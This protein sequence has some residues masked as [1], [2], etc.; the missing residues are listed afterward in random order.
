MNYTPYK[1]KRDANT[2]AIS[3]FHNSR[4]ILRHNFILRYIHTRNKINQKRNKLFQLFLISRISPLLFRLKF[5]KNRF[6]SRVLTYSQ[7]YLETIGEKKKKKK[8][9]RT[10]VTR[11]ITTKSVTRY[12]QK[13]CRNVLFTVSSLSRYYYVN[14][15]NKRACRGVGVGFNKRGFRFNSC[16]QESEPINRVLSQGVGKLSFEIPLAILMRFSAV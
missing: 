12:T 2:C 16:S 7:Y 8:P 14:N 9:N 5:K 15:D 10:R 6:E 1:L 13:N 11:K 3:I 4:T